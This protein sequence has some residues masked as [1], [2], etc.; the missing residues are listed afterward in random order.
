MPATFPGLVTILALILYAATGVNVSR[1]RVRHKVEAPAVTGSLEFERA[2]RIH[3]NTLEQLALFLPA[4][5]L[6]VLFVSPLWGGVI[7]L[8]WVAGRVFYAIA[9][10]RDP[11][12][13]GPGFAI[14][15]ISSL[16]LLLGALI[17]AIVNLR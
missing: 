15:G 6:F 10:Q 8:V 11:A 3:Q 16:V 9:Y 5:W 12:A 7:G 14:A 17:G 4:L 2:F 1:L 13:R